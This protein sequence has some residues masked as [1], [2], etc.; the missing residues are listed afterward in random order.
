MRTEYAIA[1]VM[2]EP[3]WLLQDWGMNKKAQRIRTRSLQQIDR[4]R[5][6]RDKLRID[7]TGKVGITRF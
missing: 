5:C 2:Y 1:K 3:R 7:D 6:R 4:S